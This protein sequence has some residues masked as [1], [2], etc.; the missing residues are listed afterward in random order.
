MLQDRPRL[1]GLLLSGLRISLL[2]VALGVAGARAQLLEVGE[3]DVFGAYGGEDLISLAT[4]RSQPVSQAPAVAT[5]ITAEQIREMGARTLN[6]VLETVPG[7]HVGLSSQG[8]SPIISIRGIYS[9]DN[10]QVLMLM[11][12]VP[13]TQVFFGNRG[14]RSDMPV[15]AIERVEIIRGPGSAIYG[16]DAFAGVINVITKSAADIDGVEAGARYG[17]FSSKDGWINAGRRFGELSAALSVEYTNTDGDRGRRIESDAQSLFDRQLG[18]QASLAPGPAQTDM[19]RWDIHLNLE[20]GNWRFHGWNWRQNGGTGPGGAQALDP[21]GQGKGNNYLADVRY[22]DL[23]FSEDWEIS[24]GVSYMRVDSDTENRLFPG[25]SLLPI[26]ANGNLNTANPTGL[27]L[28]PD[29]MRGNP[30]TRED[31]YRLDSFAFYRGLEDH[32]IRLGAGLAHVKL[33]PHE[34][35]NFGPGVIDGTALLPPPAINVIG[36]RLTNVTNTPF[37]FVKKKE[38]T[39]VY[40]SIQDEWSFAPDWTLVAGVRYD[41]Y[42]DFGD[43]VNPRAALIWETRHDLTS[44]LL[45]GRA[46]RAPSF[47][48]SYAINNPVKLGNSNLNPEDINYLELAFDYRPTFDLRT[49]LSLFG[50][51]I[52]DQIRFVGSTAGTAARAEN[53]GKQRAF[54][55]EVEADWDLS[56]ELTFSGNLS[57]LRAEDRK[58]KQ[59]VGLAPKF[60]AYLIGKWRFRPDWLLAPE[61]NWVGPR[62]RQPGDPR[63]GIDNYALVNLTLRRRNLADGLSAALLVKN[64]FD[65]DA[66]EPSFFDPGVPGG[67]VI[68]GD[69]PRAGRYFGGELRLEY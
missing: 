66:R 3:E 5:L 11:N 43:T 1:E 53:T 48:E 56:R 68:P 44:K 58:F 29:G 50:Y 13:F 59:S 26:G 39:D 38:R 37:I 2:A 65:K 57:S 62:D 64:V 14:L 46:F 9:D 7:V 35:K 69:Y 60:Q 51:Q 33:T 32:V 31:H 4:G 34:T 23:D 54:G 21:S 12:G 20:Y 42:S 17:S 47:V 19:R 28:F 16:A 8:F 55:A 67:A 18:T 27:V 25:G 52:D 61:L 22:H 36:G 49:G 24:A 15:G 6:E 10:P 30:D 63:S 45:Y 40:A 41:H